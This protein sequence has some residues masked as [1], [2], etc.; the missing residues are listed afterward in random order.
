MK[1]FLGFL[2]AVGLIVLV[3]ILILRGFSGHKQPAPKT[4]LSDYANTSTVV[5]LTIDSPVTADVSH[6]AV[7]VTIGR[8]QNS[9]EMFQG[10]QGKVTALYNYSNNQEAYDT[11]LRS[12]QLLGYTKG[13]PAPEKADERGY[14]ANGNRYIYEIVS[15]AAT[16]QRYWFSSCSVGTFKGNGAI[17]RNLFRKQIPDYSKVTGGFGF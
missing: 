4:A 10:Y 14:C 11:F 7:R 1:Y 2:A 16:V 13:D 6:H 8:D 3:F 9:V 5:R 15:G 12:L 17:I